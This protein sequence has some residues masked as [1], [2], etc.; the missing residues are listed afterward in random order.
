M[1]KLRLS[2]ERGDADH[3]WLRSKHTFSF[4]N[5][6]D[7]KQMGFGHLRVINEDR[8]SGGSGFG[9]HPH[10]D[11]EIISYVISGALEHQDSMGNRTVIKP[12]EVQRMSAGTGIT[13]SE[14][15]HFSEQETHFLQIWIL[16]GRNG[17]EPSYGQKSFSSALETSAFTHVMSPDGRDQTVSIGQDVDMYLG[18]GNQGSAMSKGELSYSVRPNRMIWIQQIEGELSLEEVV[19]KGNSQLAQLSA[20]DGIAV[21]RAERLRLRPNREAHFLLLDMATPK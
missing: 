7:S 20:G 6:Y 18:K 2:K 19:A 12:G 3:G 1:F 13:H 16:P 10:R 11:M 15:N 17:T 4:A 14:F 8:I 21:E 5:Y 9:T